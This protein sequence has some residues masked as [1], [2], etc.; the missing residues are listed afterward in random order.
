MIGFAVALLVVG[1]VLLILGIAVH[2]AHLL[3][4]LGIVLAVI[5]L[6]WT[7]FSGVGGRRRAARL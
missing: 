6:L 1:V 4:W 2:A 3:L 7:L 5:G